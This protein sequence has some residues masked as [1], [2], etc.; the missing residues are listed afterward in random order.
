MVAGQHPAWEL[1]GPI[2]SLPV[3]EEVLRMITSLLPGVVQPCEMSLG[4][5]LESAHAL[6]GTV[7]QIVEMLRARREH[8]GI[9]YYTVFHRPCR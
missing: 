8:L 4:D 9:S 6:V 5:V 1:A 7:D 3:A 2:A